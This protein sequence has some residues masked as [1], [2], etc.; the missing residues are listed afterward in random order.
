MKQ[1][2][3]RRK[4]LIILFKFMISGMKE[5]SSSAPFFRSFKYNTRIVLKENVRNEEEQINL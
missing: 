1:E 5:H 2:D 3:F 4:E